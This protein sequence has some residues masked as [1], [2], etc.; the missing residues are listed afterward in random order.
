MSKVEADD[1]TD[2]AGTGAPTFSQ[3]IEGVTDASSAGSGNVGEFVESASGTVT[4]DTT[5]RDVRSIS[6]TAGDWDVTGRITTTSGSAADN[7]VM[8][9]ST[10]SVTHGTAGKTLM[11]WNVNDDTGGA[12][13]HS[14]G[15]LSNV[16]INV[17][18]TTTVYLVA[19]VNAGGG[20]G[21]FQ[22]YMSARRV[23]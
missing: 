2:A 12:S 3:G 17:S 21:I 14:G 20:A 16:R 23:R 18:S 19:D 22:A 5:T 4:L 8:S 15:E 10:T 7:L 11:Y 13:S 9:I 6:L 1:I